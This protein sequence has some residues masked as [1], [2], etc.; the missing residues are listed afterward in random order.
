MVPEANPLAETAS[1]C[2]RSEAEQNAFRGAGGEGAPA[3]RKKF[4]SSWEVGGG[5]EERMLRLLTYASLAIHLP[6]PPDTCP[7]QNAAPLR[8]FRKKNTFIRKE[9]TE[10]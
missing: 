4:I 5:V 8:S 10:L 7:I 9:K 1:N 2:L 3:T 6:T